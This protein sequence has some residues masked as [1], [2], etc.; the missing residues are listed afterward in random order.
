METPNLILNAY[1]VTCKCISIH[2]CL[3]GIHGLA[4]GFVFKRLA[5][6][7]VEYGSMGWAKFDGGGQNQNFFPTKSPNFNEKFTYLKLD[8][9]QSDKNKA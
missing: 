6:W 3:W 5:E 4:C 2:F 8:K 1:Q 7:I 9:Y